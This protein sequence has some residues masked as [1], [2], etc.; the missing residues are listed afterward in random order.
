MDFQGEN[1]C[2]TVERL[3]RRLRDRV[4]EINS[5]Y[6][7]ARQTPRAVI[8]PASKYHLILLLEYIQPTDNDIAVLKI[9][10][11][12]AERAGNLALAEALWTRLIRFDQEEALSSLK[13]IWKQSQNQETVIKVGSEL[14]YEKSGEKAVNDDFSGLST[15][16][17]AVVTVNEQGKEIQRETKKA[18]YYAEDL[19]NGVTLDMVAILWCFLARLKN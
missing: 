3:N 7:K 4:K 6:K 10:T 2:A 13:Q 17:F 14:V 1:N 12:K 18:K 16:E 5:F 19:G 9:D 11:F 8:E 15:F